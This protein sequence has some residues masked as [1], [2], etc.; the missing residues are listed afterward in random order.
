[1]NVAVEWMK[2]YGEK[3]STN[4]MG[5][6]FEFMIFNVEQQNAEKIYVC[7]WMVTVAR[8]LHNNCGCKWWQYL[9]IAILV[10]II[11]LVAFETYFCFPC[12]WNQIFLEEF[13]IFS[14]WKSFTF[15]HIMFLLLGSENMENLFI[16]ASGLKIKF[17]DFTANLH[18]NPIKSPFFLSLNTIM[19]LTM[20]LTMTLSQLF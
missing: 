15:C 17:I 13:Q 4:K 12:S 11:P 6:E 5:E 1:M 7:E 3:I 8:A 2:F 19:T 9:F 18:E 16:F 20:R 10:C 14:P